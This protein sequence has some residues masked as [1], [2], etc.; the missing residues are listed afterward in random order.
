M[1]LF[2][3]QTLSMQDLF[4]TIIYSQ[5]KAYMIQNLQTFMYLVLKLLINTKLLENLIIKCI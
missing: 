4:I 2:A 5:I 1:S 3:I